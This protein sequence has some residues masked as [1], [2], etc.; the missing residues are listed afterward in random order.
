MPSLTVVAPSALAV[1]LLVAVIWA[2]APA[3][4]KPQAA[5]PAWVAMQQLWR[6]MNDAERDGRYEEALE[7]NRAIRSQTG[8]LYLITLRA[9]WLHYLKGDYAA[10][11]A[12]YRQAAALSPGAVSP[13]LGLANCQ[14]AA[15]D[16]ESALRAAQA[17]LAIDP[18]NY[19]ANRRVADLLYRKGDY[20]HAETYYLKI[21]TLYPEDLDTAAQLAWCHL[22][23]GRVSQ[24]RTI[25]GNVLIA[26]PNHAASLQGIGACDRGQNPGE[27]K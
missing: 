24:A 13:L 6:N 26:S 27:G 1:T 5:A 12:S 16:A 21:A 20:P 8:D 17:V 15:G 2:S 22:Q 9:G 25:F 23:Q 18:M 14:A 10:G 4:Q 19:P 3:P 11:S 7:Y